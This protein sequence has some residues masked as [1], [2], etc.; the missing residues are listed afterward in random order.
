MHRW[1]LSQFQR[2]STQT[3][4]CTPHAM[5]EGPIV[6]PA[7]QRV[8]KDEF[9]SAPQDST[10]DED[11][12]DWSY[13]D[14]TELV[15]LDLGSDRVAR[16]ALLGFNAPSSAD[17][18]TTSAASG[19]NGST[20]GASSWSTARSVRASRPTE[21]SIE[22]HPAYS[23]TSSSALK[24]HLGAG[25]MFS[26]TG[27]DTATP[28]LKIENTVLSGKRVDMLGSE[29][30]LV[31]HIDATKPKGAQH[32]LRPIPSAHAGHPTTNSSTTRKRILFSPIYDPTDNERLPADV[33]HNHMAHDLREAVNAVKNSATPSHAHTPDPPPQE[34]ESGSTAKRT[35]TETG[36]DADDDEENTTPTLPEEELLVR[37][38]ERSIKK[39]ARAL[40]KQQ[41]RDNEDKQ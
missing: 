10:S 38:A 21:K 41:K 22:Q 36:E 3:L 23:S 40:R 18:A 13:E 17:F 24:S 39:A 35:R 14:E 7:W 8:P 31:D 28:I 9:G 27:L 5:S 12:S 19:A 11:G 20:G 30:V 2:N 32:R 4:D 25:K 16:R 15:T 29:I 33:R 37:R 26:L 1:L 34:A 6:D